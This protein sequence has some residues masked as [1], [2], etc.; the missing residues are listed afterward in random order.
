MIPWGFLVF[1][2]VFSIRL[3]ED[4]DEDDLECPSSSPRQDEEHSDM[5]DVSVSQLGHIVLVEIDQRTDRMGDWMIVH[6]SHVDRLF[7]SNRWVRLAI[8]E[9]GQQRQS[10]MDG[11]VILVRS[12]RSVHR[13][14]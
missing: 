11:N 14:R 10:S 7:Q 3:I 9:D 4:E 8:I 1:R 13:C 5:N 6:I 2:L 12:F